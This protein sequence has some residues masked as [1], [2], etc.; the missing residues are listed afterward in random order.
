[1][2]GVL[3]LVEH[4]GSVV[5]DVPLE[6]LGGGVVARHISDLV[7]HLAVVGV[8]VGIRFATH[9]GV[10]EVVLLADDGLVLLEVALVSL[11]G[12]VA[13]LGNPGVVVV[14]G[15][16]VII[17]GLAGLHVGARVVTRGERELDSVD[18]GSGSVL[19]GEG[20]LVSDGIVL[21]VGTKDAS[22]VMGGNLEKIGGA[23]GFL[24]AR[25]V[26]A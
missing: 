21:V 20:H 12:P 14:P 1:M 6:G 16:G 19:D 11:R 5:V 4:R 3:G 25:L 23:Q 18:N 10:A 13:A 8:V 24:V 17:H 26:G 9:D 7:G 2:G 15:G 22:K